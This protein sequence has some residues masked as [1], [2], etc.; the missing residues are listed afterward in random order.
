VI[1]QAGEAPGMVSSFLDYGAHVASKMKGK[2]ANPLMKGLEF[3]SSVAKYFGFSRPTTVPMTAVVTRVAPYLSLASGAPVAA[4]PLAID[5]AVARNVDAVFPLSKPGETGVKYLTSRKCMVIADWPLGQA[6]VI[7]PG[8]ESTHSTLWF[9]T[10]LSYVSKAFQYWSGSI[11][12][13]MEVVSSPLVR[14]RLGVVIVPPFTITP[15]TYPTEAGYITHVVDVVGTTE[16]EFVVPYLYQQDMM[17]YATWDAGVA[18]GVDQTK[19]VCFALCDSVGP[20]ATPVVPP[21]NIWISAGDDFSLAGPTLD[22]IDHVTPQSGT[23]AL[24]RFGE[25]VEDVLLLA[26]RSSFVGKYVGTTNAMSFPAQVFVP[27]IGSHTGVVYTYYNFATYFSSIFLCESGGWNYTIVNG[28]DNMVYFNRIDTESYATP[29]RGGSGVALSNP[30]IDGPVQ[31]NIPDRN[32]SIYRPTKSTYT[33]AAI[34]RI[35]GAPVTGAVTVSTTSTIYCA[36]ADD[37]RFGGLMAPP[38]YIRS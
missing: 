16:F 27:D 18:A 33:D 6:M 14:W 25:V 26:R 38:P 28:V 3:G 35:F 20:A 11:K 10:S 34:W 37:Y 21:I 32:Y 12:V 22:E 15:V 9:P 5:P 4:I 1:P 19:I 30:G 23:M 31:I 17:P 7:E 2:Y 36:G 13:T 24:A 8:M 29:G